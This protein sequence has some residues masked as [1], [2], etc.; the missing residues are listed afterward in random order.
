MK[1]T[2]QDG[3]D[4]LV[5]TVQALAGAATADLLRGLTAP[6]QLTAA[7]L[8][9]ELTALGRIGRHARLAAL[10]GP[11][12]TPGDLAARLTALPAALRAAVVH[13]LPPAV[14]PPEPVAVGSSVPDASHRWGARLA[15]E[16]AAV[17]TG[18]PFATG[19]PSPARDVRAAPVIGRRGWRTS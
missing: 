11:G 4:A 2:G 15:R 10:L 3:L 12:A 17:S 14:R 6:Q 16:W 13:H 1:L 18:R 5:L 8:A 7:M 9:G 19:S